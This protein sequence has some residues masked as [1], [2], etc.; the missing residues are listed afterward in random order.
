MKI[1]CRERVEKNQKE[2]KYLSKIENKKKKTKKNGV[3]SPT[4]N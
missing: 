4:T 3:D 1:K 2:E